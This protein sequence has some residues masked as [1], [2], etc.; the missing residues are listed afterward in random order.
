MERC[1]TDFFNLLLSASYYCASVY[2]VCKY[3]YAIRRA[4][5]VKSIYKRV[6]IK[7]K[8][9]GADTAFQNR[10]VRIAES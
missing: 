4:I 7:V 6:L 1:F 2:K 5:K 3:L 8:V 10:P 9:G